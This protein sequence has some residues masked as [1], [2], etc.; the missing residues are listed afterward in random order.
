MSDTNKDN[1]T[2]E[3][4]DGADEYRDAMNKLPLEERQAQ[5]D[6]MFAGDFLLTELVD[7]A[8]SGVG[9]QVT[10]SVR[11]QLITGR[12]TSSQEFFDHTV[13]ILGKGTDKELA[14]AL[15]SRIEEIRPKLNT[16]QRIPGLPPIFIHLADARYLSE[17]GEYLPS[18]SGEP[19]TWRGKI[20]S[21]DGFS[22]GQITRAP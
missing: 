1:P 18:L 14:D 12:L 4:E 3:A 21:V 15:V 22:L 6:R 17:A 11:G 20:A 2:I 16:P 19:L 8:N 7:L 5:V 13:R 9:L 10:L